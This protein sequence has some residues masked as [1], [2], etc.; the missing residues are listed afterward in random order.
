MGAAHVTHPSDTRFQ[1]EALAKLKLAAEEAAWLT[2]RGYDTSGVIDLVVAHH[3]L[4]D[5]ER[6]AVTRGICSEPQYRRRAAREMMDE[7]VMKRPLAIDAVDLL[8]T[9][10]AAVGERWLLARIDGSYALLDEAPPL[11]ANEID[12]ALAGVAAAFK[13]LKPSKVVF[14]VREASPEAALVKERITAGA[15]AWKAVT[16]VDVVADPSKPLRKAAG[17]VSSDAGVLDACPTWFNL[18]GYVI[19]RMQSVRAL[20][21]L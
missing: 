3:A 9:L 20:R 4:D 21:L 6:L 16:T 10:S 13:E 12:L 17:A 7:D 18:A 8:S 11:A 19:G 5:G 1:G 14:Y 2:G 15:K